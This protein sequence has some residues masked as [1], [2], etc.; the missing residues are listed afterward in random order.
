MYVQNI[1][2]YLQVQI[3]LYYLLYG[4]GQQFWRNGISI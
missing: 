2:L 4:G 3:L 1:L